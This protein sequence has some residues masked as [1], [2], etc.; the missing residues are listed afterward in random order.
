MRT[1]TRRIPT[2]SSTCTR[3]RNRPTARG[4][5]PT[6]RQPRE[7]LTAWAAGNL[8][9]DP[10]HPADAT[11]LQAKGF[12]STTMRPRTSQ[13][14]RASGEYKDGRWTVVLRRPLQI[15]PDAGLAIAPGD[16]L[17]I[18]FALWEGS[19]HDRN[20]QKMVSIWHDLIV[21]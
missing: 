17:S 6:D 16:S 2:W 10:T 19:V 8:R 20:G 3:S 18:A 15:A 4:R 13:V 21:E 1:W 5:T 11:N 14:V 12:G 9:S 7:F